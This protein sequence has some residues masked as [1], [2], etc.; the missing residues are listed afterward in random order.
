MTVEV[1]AALSSGIE[2]TSDL[3]EKSFSQ[4]HSQD[5]SA[6]QA[7]KSPHQGCALAVQ[8]LM[9]YKDPAVAEESYLSLR[10]TFDFAP[11]VDLA[12]VGTE[13]ALL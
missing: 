6:A 12:V 10:H 13:S 2:V 1:L 4:A 11:A 9:H 7:A 3:E 8:G 5:E